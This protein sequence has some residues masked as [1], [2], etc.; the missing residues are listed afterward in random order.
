MGCELAFRELGALGQVDRERDRLVAGGEE[1]GDDRRR[2][3]FGGAAIEGLSLADAGKNDARGFDACWRH[4]VEKLSD[5]PL[6]TGDLDRALER[7]AA[8]YVRLDCR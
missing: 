3:P 2:E 5:L 7:A 8:R 6:E 4:D 1:L